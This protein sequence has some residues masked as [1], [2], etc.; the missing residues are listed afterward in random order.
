MK[1]TKKRVLSVLAAA[2][3]SFSAVPQSAIVLKPVL[4]ASAETYTAGNF[5]YEFN[6]DNSGVI[7]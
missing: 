2:A 7:I 5:N 1:N 3:L 4:T 6:A